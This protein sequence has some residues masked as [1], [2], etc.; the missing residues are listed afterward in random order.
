MERTQLVSAYKA[1]VT[2]LANLYNQALDATGFDGVVIH[3]GSLQKR[4]VFDDQH[5]PLRPVPHFQHWAP[6]PWPDCAM[7]VVRGTAPRLVVY[8]DC[9][10]WER[11]TQPDF[12]LIQSALEVVNA[13]SVEDVT[14]HIPEE[15]KV[16][17]IGE[18]TWRAADWNLAPEAINPSSLLGALD[19]VRVFKTT[20]EQM[21]LREANRIAARGHQRVAREFQAGER[22]EFQLHLA[23]L[24]ETQQDDGE[25][26]YKNIVA[27]GN[28]AAILHH[29]SYRRERLLGS[30]SLLVD[31]GAVVCGY[32]SDITRTHVSG[33]SAEAD[34]F[35]ALVH[36]VDGMQ[37]KLCQ[38]AVPGRLYESLHDE[39][40]RL[41][42][43][44]LQTLG[45]VDMPEEE[46]VQ[47]GVTRLFLPHG[48]GH[49]LGLQC[50][51][52]G[53]AKVAPRPENKWLRNTRVIEAEQCFTIEP[54]VYFIDTLMDE[55]K[56]GPHGARVKWKNVDALRSFG[57]VRIE[58]DLV[59]QS[60]GSAAVNLTR[61]EFSALP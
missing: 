51:D 9:S 11:W 57:G 61:G 25:T 15:G 44:I 33:T 28:S 12:G 48:L 38:A 10:Y 30:Q 54:G 20:Y 32:A 7:L 45:L 59:V 41:V 29:V 24:S 13:S 37:Q 23:Y 21:C 39:A 18:N 49:S 52:V 35:G 31:A 56:A 34:L 36:Q 58:D 27:V 8:K 50:H 17:F 46:M 22:S 2:H 4:S 42:A 19:D 53:C 14:S 1:H 5:W 55:L 47:G 43:G 6:L 60:T 40:H 3:S 26:P 16:A